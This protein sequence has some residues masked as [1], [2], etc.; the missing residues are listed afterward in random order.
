MKF[1]Q[2]LEEFP[3]KRRRALTS[4]LPIWTTTL[5]AITPGKPTWSNRPQAFKLEASGGIR[6]E[7]L[8]GQIKVAAR[9]DHAGWLG[10][11]P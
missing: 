4:T 1:K 8:A 3:R 6:V 5:I 7:Y 9:R 11:S 2:L 10:C